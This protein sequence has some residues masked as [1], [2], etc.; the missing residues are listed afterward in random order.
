MV[1]DAR[2]NRMISADSADA[3]AN[4]MISADSADARAN[5]MISA[6]SADARTNRMI[7]ADSADARANRMISADSADARANRMISADSADARATQ[8]KI[9]IE[10]SYPIVRATSACSKT[11][12]ML[13]IFYQFLLI[14][15]TII[16]LHFPNIDILADKVL[17][18]LPR[19]RAYT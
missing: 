2:A 4:R 1:T 7:S 19:H 8:I 12:V 13:F 16:Y 11:P 6:D 10:P 3:Q 9:K 5:R 18:R 14:Q 15:R 17:E